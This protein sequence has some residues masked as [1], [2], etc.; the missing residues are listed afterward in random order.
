MQDNS[1]F[2]ISELGSPWR[3][4]LKFEISDFATARGAWI[5]TKPAPT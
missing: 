4:N 1:R 2:E 3:G 5:E